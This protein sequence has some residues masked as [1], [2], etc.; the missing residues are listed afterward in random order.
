MPSG[1]RRV[2]DAAINATYKQEAGLNVN[3]R[4]GGGETAAAAG[5]GTEFF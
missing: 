4:F 2:T 1:E 5:A 3:S